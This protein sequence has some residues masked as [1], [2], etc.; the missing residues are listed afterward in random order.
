M[1]TTFGQN[2][3]GIYGDR[4]FWGGIIVSMVGGF[5]IVGVLGSYSTLGTPSV[6]TASG[7]ARIAHERVWEYIK[8]NS[9]RYMFS[10]RMF[11]VGFMCMGTSA[12]IEVLSR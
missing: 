7:D 11:L 2:D 3:P 9:G 10:F 8:T 5:V 1:G 4:L 12:L 6:L